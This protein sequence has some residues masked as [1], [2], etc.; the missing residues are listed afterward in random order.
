MSDVL[1]RRLRYMLT[2]QFDLYASIAGKLDGERVLEVGCGT[3]FGALQLA[4]RARKVNAID[5]DPDAI[6]FAKLTLQSEHL[7]FNCA[8]IC[9]TTSGTLWVHDAAVMIEVLEHISDW[10]TALTSVAWLLR[11][12]GKLYISARNANADLR[13]NDLHER[14]VTAGQFVEMLS[15]HFSSVKLYDYTLEHELG[16][17]TRATPLVAVCVK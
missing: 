7:R 16:T 8:D 17:D 2:P 6:G 12:G 4:R 1:W 11:D 3:G 15:A 13:R 5:I 14:E 9:N 10:Q